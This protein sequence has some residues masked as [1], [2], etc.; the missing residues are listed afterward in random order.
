MNVWL[1]IGLATVGIAL[2]AQGFFS[3]SE[4]AFVSA[5]RARLEAMK[6][7]GNRGAARALEMLE[8]EDQLLGTCLIGTNV[9]LITGAT[10]VSGMVLSRGG[11]ELLATFAL[12][13][14]ALLLGEAVPKT[15]YQHH[16]N[17]LAPIL[18]GPL[19]VAQV[20]FTPMLW[21]VGAWAK[22]LGGALDRESHPS[23]QELVMLLDADQGSDIK[24]RERRI[25]RRVLG[26]DDLTV[27]DAMTPLVDVRAVSRD[28][29]IEDAVAQI[30]KHGHSRLLVYSDRVDNIIGVIDHAAL[31]FGAEPGQSVADRM[32]ILETYTPEVKS[33]RELLD[34]MR[35]S[36][37]EL[38]VVVDEYGGVV[39][40]VTLEDLL[41]ELFGEIHDERDVLEPSIRQ[42]G[43]REWRIPARTEL[44][45]VERAIGRKL[46]EGAYETVAGLILDHTGRIPAPDETVV[47]DDMR[48]TIEQGNARAVLQVRLTLP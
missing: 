41:E 47:I 45:A 27:E 38:R 36:G 6:A 43:E 23:R 37:E 33:A 21:V 13:P 46:P 10:V 9:S 11:S 2:V 24:P 18:S 1:A 26:L 5:N 15:V 32:E 17:T 14:F 25:I 20:L 3:G 28:A 8:R 19:R 35:A 12:A 31:L 48:L 44:E 30:L 39:G 7:E 40:M 16:A 34:E 42:I 29:P 22:L 4:M